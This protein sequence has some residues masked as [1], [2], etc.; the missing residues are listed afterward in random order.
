[1]APGQRESEVE[2]GERDVPYGG[3]RVGD[4]ER[5]VVAAGAQAGD[6]AGAESTGAVGDQPL[7]GAAVI[8]AATGLRTENDRS[9]LRHVASML[10]SEPAKPPQGEYLRVTGRSRR[11]YQP[12]RQQ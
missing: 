9:V 8:D 4:G 6:R 11:R 5:R 7:A 1:L 10:K 12:H 2:G 3:L